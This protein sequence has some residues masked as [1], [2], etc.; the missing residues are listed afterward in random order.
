[1]YSQFPNYLAGNQLDK[2]TS[3]F[4]YMIQ[5]EDF[6]KNINVINIDKLFEGPSQTKKNLMKWAIGNLHEFYKSKYAEWKKT[7]KPDRK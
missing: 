5:V 7:A 6:I 4:I 3:G 2:S 1:M